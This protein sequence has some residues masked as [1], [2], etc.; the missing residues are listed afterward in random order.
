LI[1]N[2]QRLYTMST[3]DELQKLWLANCP[4]FFCKREAELW[5]TIQTLADRQVNDR[6]QIA[7]NEKGSKFKFVERQLEYILILWN[8]VIKIAESKG[9]HE[10]DAVSFQ[11]FKILPSRVVIGIKT[12][13]SEKD[14]V[15]GKKGEKEKGKKEKGKKDEKGKRD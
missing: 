12:A 9:G 8:H 14:D 5:N 2:L 4:T 13:G 10:F 3:L 7:I 1:N 6:L 11:A 15:K